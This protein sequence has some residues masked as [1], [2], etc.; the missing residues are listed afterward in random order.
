MAAMNRRV[1]SA[2][3]KAYLAGVS[4]SV[5][6]SIGGQVAARDMS[7][8]VIVTALARQHGI[9][10]GALLQ[11]AMLRQRG[12]DVELLDAAP[13]LRNPLFRIPHRAATSYVFHSGGPQTP[14]MIASVL[15]AAARAYRIG[16]WAWEL[17]SPPLDWSGYER[18]L[19]EIWT[20]SI[21]SRDA[22]SGGFRRPISVVPHY[23]PPRP[24][25]QRKPGSPFTVLAMAD[26]RSS[27]SRKNPEGAFRAFRRAF[28]DCPSA[29]LILK[30]KGHSDATDTAKR[31]LGQVM[32]GS[33]V[34]MVA[35]H[36]DD[37]AL[38]DLYERAD[39]LLSLHRSEGFGLPM[40]EAMARGIPVV[41]TGWSGNL[42]FMDES[43]SSLVPYK[44]VQVQDTSG[45][46]ATGTWAEPDLDAAADQLRRLAYD[47][48]YYQLKAEAAYRSA[49]DTIPYVPIGRRHDRELASCLPA[50]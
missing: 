22:L 1:K 25:R 20:P 24:M 5:R 48:S 23:V 33:N 36:L 28:G 15:P 45:V 16:Y 40:R 46:Y 49:S 43:N 14:N 9:A 27:L 4:A 41:A 13:A 12:V 17:P 29:R 32:L 6:R 18:D 50:V 39:L 38:D 35:G 8:V 11:Y 34:E 7:R 26:T 44:L 42:D 30:I 2:L 37:L 3:A 19:D 21:F 10:R 31:C 47:G